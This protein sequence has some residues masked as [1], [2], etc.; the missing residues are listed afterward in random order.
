MRVLYKLNVKR[1]RV[2][3]ALSTWGTFKFRFFC[4]RKFWFATETERFCYRS[5]FLKFSFRNFRRWL[6]LISVRHLKKSQCN[7]CLIELFVESL[8]YRYLKPAWGR[9][10]LNRLNFGFIE[11]SQ[12]IK[13]LENFG[14]T[15]FWPCCVI[16]WINGTGLP[17][18]P[19]PTDWLD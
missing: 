3:L 18:E 10:V 2:I 15:R 4:S 11:Y 9:H 7:Q 1:E 16:E 6:R 12:T 14:S 19:A 17:D 5:V 8:T 13:F